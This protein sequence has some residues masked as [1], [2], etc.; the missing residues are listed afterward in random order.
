[1]TLKNAKTLEKDQLENV[2]GGTYLETMADAKELYERGIIDS[3]NANFSTIRKALHDLGYKDYKNH[4]GLTHGNEYADKNGN[5]I[6][7]EEFWKTFES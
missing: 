4:G 1:M 2:A 3:P 5:P 7:R 6:S